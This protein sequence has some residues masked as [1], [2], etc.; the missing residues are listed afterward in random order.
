LFFL[1]FKYNAFYFLLLSFSHYSSFTLYLSIANDPVYVN[2]GLFKQQ[3]YSGELQRQQLEITK[4]KLEI[5]SLRRKEM[6][7]MQQRMGGGEENEDAPPRRRNMMRF[8]QN[9][10]PF[11]FF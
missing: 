8:P 5:R 9:K 10:M 2:S 4:L 7:A 1:L 11:R 6:E 3:F